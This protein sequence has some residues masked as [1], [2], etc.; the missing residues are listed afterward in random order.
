MLEKC[1]VQWLK[2]EKKQTLSTK[3]LN[4]VQQENLVQRPK[5]KLNKFN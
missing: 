5:F 1:L 2:S 3:D 4:L